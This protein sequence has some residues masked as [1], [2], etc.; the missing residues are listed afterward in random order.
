MTEYWKPVVGYEGL[1]EV[2]N[3]G[4][5]RSVDRIS[6]AGSRL[7][8]VTLA[9]F[10]TPHG[11]IRVGMCKQGE[12]K[13]LLVHPLVLEAFVGP[14]PDG[15]DCRH[16]NDQPDDNRVENLQWGT[17]SQNTYDSVR[18]GSHINAR[19]THCIRGHEFS[20]SNLYIAPKSGKRQCKTCSSDGQRNRIKKRR[21]KERQS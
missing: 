7:K 15:S 4:G 17:R 8:G 10:K 19:K 9:Q 6:S 2:S 13:T 5:V 16:L 1:Y 20:G 18:N 12:T 21:Q 3:R 14:R 11:Y